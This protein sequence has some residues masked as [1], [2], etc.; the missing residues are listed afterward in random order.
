LDQTHGQ[1]ALVNN[2]NLQETINKT[3]LLEQK[4]NACKIPILPGTLSDVD[5]F[6]S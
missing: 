5:L 6:Y 4:H 2:A 3:S 1:Q